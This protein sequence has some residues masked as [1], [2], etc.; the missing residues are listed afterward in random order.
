M[1]KFELVAPDLDRWIRLATFRLAGAGIELAR[2]E[3]ERL[4]AHG[5]GV[6]WADVWT[7][8]HRTIDV[9]VTAKL[10]RLVARRVSGEPLAYIEGSRGF[11]GLELAC[12]PGVL[13]PR[14]ETEVVVEV[15]LDLIA[16]LRDPCVVDIGTGSGAISLAIAPQRA[17]AEV[18]ATDLS[19]EALAYARRNA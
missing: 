18:V 11:Y 7:S 4:A 9:S 8:R 6:R 10:D 19:E 15:A 16:D 12:G 17:D 5:I 13:V 1:G 14:P 3:A 2:F